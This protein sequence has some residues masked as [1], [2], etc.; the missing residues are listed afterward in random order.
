[1]HRL[2]ESSDEPLTQSISANSALV[3]RASLT[4]KLSLNL[5]R[6]SPPISAETAILLVPLEEGPLGALHALQ[7]LKNSKPTSFDRLKPIYIIDSDD[8]SK[9]APL[10]T[11]PDLTGRAGSEPVPFGVWY[12]GGSGDK[13]LNSVH[14]LE[15]LYR[16]QRTIDHRQLSLNVRIQVPRIGHIQRR[17]QEEADYL[18]VDLG[19]AQDSDG[20]LEPGDLTSYPAGMTKSDEDEVRRVSGQL[21]K[22]L[23]FKKGGTPLSPFRSVE[24]LRSR[25]FTRLSALAGAPPASGGIITR[26][27]LYRFVR[28]DAVSFASVGCQYQWAQDRLTRELLTGL[29]YASVVRIKR[30]KPGHDS[31][32]DAIE[33]GPGWDALGF[34]I[35]CY[36]DYASSQT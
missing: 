12:D 36:I 32:D 18:R 29:S 31:P 34:L 8:Y 1:M 30:K 25:M 21:L 10:G 6:S 5:L 15:N 19:Y 2:E 35:S 24:V 28:A 23:L 3:R 33:L 9:A 16:G 14:L 11:E 20:P 26:N 7:E 13:L 22:Y 17:L 4:G 27:E